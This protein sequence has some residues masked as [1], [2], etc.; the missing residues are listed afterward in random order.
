MAQTHQFNVDNNQPGYVSRNASSRNVNNL[1]TVPCSKRNR[2]N[3]NS[4][5]QLIRSKTSDIFELICDTKPDIVAIT[6]TW[7]TTTDSAV[8]AEVYPE[9]YKIADFPRI[10]RRG[11]GT[12]LIYRDSL[13][14]K[15]ADAGQKDSKSSRNGWYLRNLITFA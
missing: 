6:E 9:G 2:N 7:L 14:I 1:I 11:G 13:T 12:A 3:C 10:G 15:R 5:Q 4:Q 8:K